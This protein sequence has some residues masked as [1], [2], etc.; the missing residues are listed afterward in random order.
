MHIYEFL[1]ISQQPD[2]G[3]RHYHTR[4]R[5]VSSRCNF[6]VHCPTCVSDISYAYNVVHFKL[7][8]GLQ[9]SEIKEDLLSCKEKSLE[10]TV[11]TIEAKESRK[12]ARQKVIVII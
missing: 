2:E 6:V 3:V 7:I 5:G 9:D 12:L 8:T 10:D 1:Q 11:K 4:L